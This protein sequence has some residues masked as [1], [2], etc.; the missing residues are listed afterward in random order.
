MRYFELDKVDRFATSLHL[1]GFSRTENQSHRRSQHPLPSIVCGER[2]L[3]H[4]H[5]TPSAH[6]LS[7]LRMKIA[8]GEGV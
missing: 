1:S 2:R 8:T 4:G 6:Q 7:A 3:A 5:F